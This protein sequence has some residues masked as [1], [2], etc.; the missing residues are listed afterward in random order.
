MGEHLTDSSLDIDALLA[1]TEDETCGALVIFSGAVR[2]NNEGRTVDSIDY[3]AHTALAEKTLREIEQETREKF[4]VPQ[5]RLVHRVGKLALGE[6]SVLVVVRAGHR[7]EAFE[8]ARWAI[9]SLKK[10]VPIW[11]EEFYASG[12]SEYL[13]GT[14]LESKISDRP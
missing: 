1:E 8:A 13:D 9:D 10:R 6:L 4:G 11:K 2:L 14:P 12:D 3:S 5:C 7:P